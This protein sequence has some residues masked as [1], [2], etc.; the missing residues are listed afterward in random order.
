MSVAIQWLSGVLLVTGLLLIGLA[1]V[2]LLRLRDA[3]GR[4]N[5][6]GKAGGLGVVCVVAGSALAVADPEAGTKAVLAIVFQ[7]ITVPVGSFAIARAAYRA[8][9]PLHAST[10]HDELAPQASPHDD[11]T[12]RAP[13]GPGSAPSRGPA[14]ERDGG[15]GP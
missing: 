7:L 13:L 10:A 8:A 12:G 11:T 15:A 2:G 5:A 1:A 4:M 9:T 6:A 3:Y 14:P